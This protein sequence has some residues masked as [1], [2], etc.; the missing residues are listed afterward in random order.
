MHKTY[1]FKIQFMCEWSLLRLNFFCRAMFTDGLKE[2]NQDVIS[3]NGVTANGIISIIEF[4][5]TS[6]MELDLGKHLTFKFL[7]FQLLAEKSN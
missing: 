2:T 3:M 7:I 1:V 6:S 4:A 5:Y